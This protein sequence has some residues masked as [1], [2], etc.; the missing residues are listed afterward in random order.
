MSEIDDI[1]SNARALSSTIKK[2]KEKGK[3]KKRKRTSTPSV[4]TV[5][6][7]SSQP[8]SKRLK[9]SKKP[10]ASVSKKAKEDEEK[11]KDSRGT[12]PRA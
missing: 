9:V 7:T 4:E 1:F 6:D 12:G 11:F 2:D 3:D 8:S 10:E 5:V